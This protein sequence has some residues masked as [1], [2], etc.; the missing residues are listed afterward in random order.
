MRWL[1]SD[2]MQ[3]NECTYGRMVITADKKIGHVV[4]V[5]YNV[6]IALTGGMS[7]DELFERTIPLVKFADGERGIHHGNIEPFRG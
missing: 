4:G 6:G 7:N 2:F 5:T 3:L 1:A